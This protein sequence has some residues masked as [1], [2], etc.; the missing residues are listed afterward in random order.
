M[1]RLGG[2]V[3]NTFLAL[4][5]LPLLVCALTVSTAF[6]QEDPAT[7]DGKI[8]VKLT[9]QAK[10]DLLGQEDGLPQVL[11]ETQ[12]TGV[13]ALD[14]LAQQY[15]VERMERVFR[16]AGKHEPRHVEWGLD[17]WYILNYESDADP[18]T[19]A[20]DYLTAE[21]EIESASPMYEKAKSVLQQQ[22][23]G[24]DD[25]ED[26]AERRAEREAQIERN[27]IPDDPEYSTQWHYNNT[28]DNVG[29]T[30]ADI[31]LPEA[32]DIET[33]DSD[34]IVS[35]VDSGLDLD[36]PDIEPILWT[37][38]DEVPGNGVDDDDNGFV[39]DVHGYDHVNGD[40][41]PESAGDDHGVHV[42]GTVAAKNGNGQFGAGVAGGDG[43]DGSGV[44]LM[45]NKTFQ[46]FS[47][48]G[49]PEAIAYG[50]DNGAVISQNSWGY[51]SEGAFEQAVLDAIDY[52]RANAGGPNAPM[53]GGIFV[54]AAGN[55]DSDGEWYPGFY[56]PSYAVS[57]TEATD[58]KAAYSN[59]GDWIDMAAP[60][61]R[62]DCVND[63]GVWST[64]DGGFG[65]LWGTSMAAPHVSGV[66]G[67]VV[68][69]NEGLTNDQV[70][71]IL[72]DTGAD[73]SDNQP[74]RMGP[75]V[76]AQAAVAQVSSDDTPPAAIMDLAAQLIG[77]NED[78]PPEVFISEVSDS[79]DGNFGNAF[80]EIYNNRATAVDL[81]S[82]D[83][84]IRSDL[85]DDGETVFNFSD[86]SAASDCG[87]TIQSGETLVIGRD[88]SQSDFEDEWGDLPDS[89]TFCSPFSQFFVGATARVWEVREGGQV[90][91]DTG[92][93]PAGGSDNRAFQV[94]AGSWTYGGD[95]A[96]AAPGTPD[97]GDGDGGDSFLAEPFDDESQ[98]DVTQGQTFKD[99]D[100]FLTITDGSDVPQ[101][102]SG[103]D[104]TYLAAANTDGPDGVDGPSQLLWSGVDISG[105]SSLEFVGTFGA[106]TGADYDGS[107]TSF[108]A[109]RME[110][111]YRVDGGEWNDLIAFW[112]D[113]GGFS[114]DLREDT[115]F[116]GV[117]DGT[118]IN[119]GALS[120]FTKQIGETGSTLDLRM[121]VNSTLSEEDI[122]AD[123]FRI[124]TASG[125]T[126]A[127]I[128]P[129]N[130]GPGA[131]AEL[132]WTAP[133]D[134]G[135]TGTATEYD[136]RFSTDGA[137][138]DSTDFADAT[139]IL[140]VPNPEEA[141]TEQSF[142][143]NGLP[144][145]TETHFAIRSF[146][147]V[148][149]E[150]DLS[151]SPSVQTQ[152]GPVASI[153]PDTVS[154]NVVIGE[155]ATATATLSNDGP[156]DFSYNIDGTALPDYLSASPASGSVSTGES[157]DIEFTFDASDLDLGQFEATV[158]ATLENGNGETAIVSV[159]TVLNVDT[160]PFPFTVDAD[161][162]QETLQN[163]PGEEAG[164]VTRTI[165]ITNNTDAPQDF[166]VL[167]GAAASEDV[168]P[169]STTP[170][171]NGEKLRDWQRKTKDVGFGLSG[172]RGME[173]KA[174]YEGNA[175]IADAPL[176]PNLDVSPSALGSLSRL[177]GNST[178]T[179]GNGTGL[180]GNFIDLPVDDPDAASTI[181]TSPTAYAGNYGYGR[182]ESFFV[183][184]DDDN[185]FHRIDNETGEI[186]T[187]GTAEPNNPSYESWN[188]IAPD[189]TDGTLYAGTTGRPGFG[190]PWENRIY[191]LDPQ[192]GEAQLV[193]EV[194]S[195]DLINAY[196]I[197]GNGQLYGLN[198]NSGELVEIDR[199]TGEVSSVGLISPLLNFEQGMDF[200]L[201]S[202]KL[203]ISATE[204]FFGF[205]F[206][207]LIEVDPETGDAVFLGSAAGGAGAVLG[208]LALPSVG[209]AQPSISQGTLS[210]GS[211]ID[212]DITLN[213]ERLNEDTY[214]SDMI[215]KSNV[216]GEPTEEVPVTLSVDGQ[217]QLAVT[218]AGDSVVTYDSTF[219][220]D[221][222]ATE[223]VT[224]RNTGTADMQATLS[225]GDQ[226]TASADS[227]SLFPGEAETVGVTFTPT[228]TGEFSQALTVESE[229]STDTVDLEGVALARPIAELSQSEFDV[230][231]YP[232]QEYTRTLTMENTGGDA[233][234]PENTS[235]EFVGM[236]EN[237][238]TPQAIAPPEIDEDFEDGVPPQ[239]WQAVDE[240]GEGVT[241][242]TNEDYGRDNWTGDG[243]SAHVDS[244]ENRNAEYDARLIS[245]EKTFDENTALVFSLVFDVFSGN[246][247]FDVDISTDGGNTWETVRR[248]EEDTGDDEEGGGELITISNEDMADF[249]DVGDTFQVRF[250]YWTPE[251]S[252]W[253][254][255]VQIDDVSF[256]EP[257]EFFAF[258]PT[259]GTIA[260]GES[261]DLTLSFNAT[262][263]VS[264][265][266]EV[267]MV[268][269]TN[270]PAGDDGDG[271]I[272][273]P[274]TIDVI[275][276]VSMT[277]ATGDDRNPNEEYTMDFNVESL[278][279]LAVSSYDMTMN[280]PSDS[281]QI[282]DV[283][284]EGTLSEGVTLSS[285]IDNENGTLTISAFDAGTSSES[286]D[287]VTLF[288]IEGQGTL[289][290][291]DVKMAPESGNPK[292]GQ[293]EM[294]F[295]EMTFN[296]GNPPVAAKDHTMEIAPLYGDVDI[297]LFI[298][299]ADAALA[300][301]ASAGNADLFDAQS[302]Q[303]DV[304]GD[305]SVSAFDASLIAQFTVGEISSFPV[306]DSSNAE[307][308]TLAAKSSASENQT[309]ASLAWGEIT[310]PKQETGGE[311]SSTLKLPLVLNQTK[312]GIYSLEVST[313]LDP[314]IV[315]VEDVKSQLP[316][317]WRLA[318]HVSD[319]GTMDIAMAGPR[320]L[321]E[322]GKVATLTLNRENS[323][324][325][326]EM[327][328]NVAI[329]E[330]AST[331]LSAKSLANIPEEFSLEG[332]Y[333]NPFRQSATLEMD[334][335]KKADVTV[336]VY[337]LLGRKV[338]TAHSG[339]LSAGAGR[340]VRIIGSDLSSGTYFYRARV[341]MGDSQKVK[342]GKMTVVK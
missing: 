227:V 166:A 2:T 260:P 323:D 244:D 156:V 187:L 105:E 185:A 218:P 319:D 94:A 255:Y 270:A 236:E 200:D 317:S 249:V 337:D 171:Y 206:E 116:D 71:Q 62:D 283:V 290:S 281:M 55:S 312:Q 225:I 18:E 50:A 310:R 248:F 117:G 20:S 136:I 175:Q 88:A 41:T 133:G 19:V 121:T 93:E 208:Y 63:E 191:E 22:D 155:T 271:T 335:P 101:D 150:S 308:A 74:E 84:S 157:Q 106:S 9:E 313:K 239:D 245:P 78:L 232:G 102:L 159:E 246:E 235:L 211:S 40:G 183:I 66:I 330:D 72:K 203:F 26:A 250:R 56:D 269:E 316:D 228:Q 64:V 49:F 268:F 120:S 125:Q 109:D 320:P 222:S 282:Q 90:L 59:Y 82:D 253:D 110:L 107:G 149:N 31:N 305:G 114:N 7:L 321:T 57:A 333:P 178:V 164:E 292:L 261:K 29:E 195:D 69:A 104:G 256:A 158:E 188:E 177:T 36:H 190:D 79:K 130:D 12:R 263:L 148:G 264:G 224:I 43:S 83:I 274:V 279:D 99:G 231:M 296:E 163:F 302:T 259:S 266:Y 309:E 5:V 331:E 182:D 54:N 21:A 81:S 237:V 124:Q 92:G 13:A 219:T 265:T 89:A 298:N 160:A 288:D 254:W 23:P 3:L 267:D 180:E 52:F 91:D 60:G 192:T 86:G 32:H 340:T 297:N 137:I 165:S 221:T 68:S 61:G 132:S 118:Q 324:A 181:G 193:T 96:N 95:P 58:S 174:K 37:N 184:T 322:T 80:L 53:D 113:G 240:P 233:S 325:A 289:I 30:D 229:D 38:E 28:P 273:V 285:N 234:D 327:A 196:A 129:E 127:T 169:F 143:V 342:T 46:G 138:E 65:C 276:N 76:D 186:T 294:N 11:T 197:D 220:Q 277:L 286:G 1:A 205:I 141:G 230:Q 334:L 202:G 75:R 287:D 311:E 119:T 123:E 212:V 48:G 161:P 142:V 210:P 291:A 103:N 35:L 126:V 172:E 199:Q 207:S 247:S 326:M 47:A 67:L 176:R 307:T 34:V 329:N 153:T 328:G 179:F 338:Q 77:A 257:T 217:S 318:H 17:R 341:K 70:E 15:N 251:T 8:Q 144:F 258:E 213:A 151:N 87:G 170:L 299:I 145:D 278:D 303:A 140:D 167:G 115:D 10:T 131:A 275:E 243:L 42:G 73:I 226:F 252:P 315:S 198:V 154:T 98:F 135:N 215:V 139:R 147:A 14:Q 97:F 24:D 111:E 272:T 194:N 223:F 262:N 242:Q 146:D 336:E 16:P 284:T 100:S 293:M 332:A 304:S 189:P 300:L 295:D 214:D 280:F 45:S 112:P 108:P 33:G 314:D 209:F 168:T 27:A 44:R 51:T 238:I 128:L 173:V 6:A 85:P 204:T 216:A 39:D 201:K 301:D 306:A 4:F 25:D 122:A 152:E 134:D 162:I 339:E 241:W